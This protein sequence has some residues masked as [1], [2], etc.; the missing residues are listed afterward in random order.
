MQ[1]GYTQVSLT[2]E[3]RDEL[4][5]ETTAAFLTLA[6]CADEMM[7]IQQ[8]LLMAMGPSPEEWVYKKIANSRSHMLLRTLN[9]KVYETQYA[10]KGFEQ[11]M[12]RRELDSD[13]TLQELLRRWSAVEA[14][15]RESKFFKLCHAMRTHLAGHIP[16]SEV[17][18]WLES[19]PKNSEERFLFHETKA[20]S[21]FI[22]CDDLV[23]AAFLNFHF[24][25]M[26]CDVD[27]QG[28]YEEF[29]GWIIDAANDLITAFHWTAITVFLDRLGKDV[30]IDASYR[31]EDKFVSSYQEVVLPLILPK[32]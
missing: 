10:F 15:M 14:K 5:P 11:T 7:Q 6:F 4:G 8:L 27:N 3:D 24:S 31:I 16:V 32:P 29:L 18:K 26:Q 13:Q 12:R 19:A 9:L 28:L 25:E 2:Q 23:F 21:T 1:V 22:A 30:E 17:K 20:N